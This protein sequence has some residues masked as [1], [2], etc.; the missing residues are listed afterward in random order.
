VLAE[1]LAS[2]GREVLVIDRR[3][4]IGGNAFDEYD[5]HGVLIHRYGPHLFHTNSQQVFEYLT[6]FTQWRSYE[7]RVLTWVDRQWLPL[8]INQDTINRLYGLNLDEEGVAAFF[9]RVREARSPVLTSEDVVLNSVGREL[10][11]KFFRNYTRKQWGLDLSELSAG[12]AARIPVRTNRDDRYFG[13]TYQAMPLNGYTAMFRNL[14]DHPRIRVE[15]DVDFKE[16]RKRARPKLTIYTGPIDEY[17]D[18]RFGKLPY[19][20]L[21]FEH[22]HKAGVELLQPVC[23]LNYPNDYEFTRTTEFKHATGQQ[24]AGTSI[25]R[26]FPT[27]EGDPYYPVPRP[28]NQALYKQYEVAAASERDTIFVGRLAQYRYYNMDQAVAASL[29]VAQ[30]LLGVEAGVR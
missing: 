12:V 13:D 7:H 23:T 20:S 18:R 3:T 11:E 14:L 25:V 26:E 19:R 10:C 22:E 9:E 27:D 4:H 24:H 16:L 8:P 2:A 30:D 15:L 1:R 21:R 17:F 6:R 5:A 29:K 28:E